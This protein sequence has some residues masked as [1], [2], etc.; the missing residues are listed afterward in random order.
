MND[1]LNHKIPFKESLK[2]IGWS[3]ILFSGTLWGVYGGYHYFWNQR[4]EDPRYNTTVLLQTSLEKEPLKSSFLAELLEISVDNPT[5]LYQFNLRMGEEKLISFPLIK[6][7]VLKRLPPGTLHIDYSI[8]KPVAL[9][10]DFTNTAID[11]ERRLIPFKPFFS[12]KKLP[13]IVLGLQNT[14]LRWGMQLDDSLGSLSFKILEILHK[15][16]MQSVVLTIDVSHI[17]HSSLGSQKAVVV[18]EE[19]VEGQPLQFT[20]ILNAQDVEDGIHRFVMLKNK[21]LYRMKRSAVIDLRLRGLAF[22]Q[23]T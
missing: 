18:I 21:L 7:A 17:E 9:V 16:G 12:P 3:V 11:E 23:T 2:A 8:R 13:S 4:L 1:Y 6:Q 5:N 14:N 20:L 22:I 19:L 15:K 10:G